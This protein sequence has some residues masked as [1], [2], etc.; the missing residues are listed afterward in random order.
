[1]KFEALHFVDVVRLACG[2]KVNEASH[3][4]LFYVHQRIKDESFS[5]G[6]K[7]CILDSVFIVC[8][9]RVPERD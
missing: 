1:M 6:V 2:V 9:F 7:V 8:G 5:L 4:Q 3:R